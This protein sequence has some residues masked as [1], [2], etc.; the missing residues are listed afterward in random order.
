MVERIGRASEGRHGLVYGDSGGTFRRLPVAGHIEV[1][2]VRWVCAQAERASDVFGLVYDLSRAG[3]RAYAPEAVK[4][5][6]RGRVAGSEARRKVVRCEPVFGRYLFV[7]QP[8]GLW[9]A[10]SSHRRL[11]GV[12]GAGSGEYAPVP[13]RVVAAIYAADVAGAWDRR[14]EP[15]R[16]AFAV[17]ELVRIVEGPFRGLEASVDDVSEA[18]R[19]V[20]RLGI[21]GLTVKLRACHLERV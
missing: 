4:V 8:S 21:N 11:A 6:L 12:L 1:E 5:A 7:G 19:G 9:L 3:F 16:A 17:G 13:A 20:V 14:V 15:E 2:G 10:K 18:L